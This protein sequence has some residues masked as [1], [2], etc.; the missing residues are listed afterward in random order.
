VYF[1]F[2]FSDWLCRKGG[3][4]RKLRRLFYSRQLS[5]DNHFERREHASM[6]TT[7]LNSLDRRMT[8]LPVW[9]RQAAALCML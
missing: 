9:Q 6:I 8:A 3:V 5:I 2:Q 4:E 7:P 1:L